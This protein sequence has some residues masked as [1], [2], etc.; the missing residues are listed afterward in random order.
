MVIPLVSLSVNADYINISQCNSNTKL[1][2]IAILTK[3]GLPK[4]DKRDV[5]EPFKSHA[6]PLNI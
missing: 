1:I 3:E 5:R 2:E 6:N 4:V